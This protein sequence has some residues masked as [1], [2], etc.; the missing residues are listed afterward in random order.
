MIGRYAVRSKRYMEAIHWFFD[1]Y[2]YYKNSMHH[3]VLENA[4][5]QFQYLYK[6]QN[7]EVIQKTLELRGGFIENLIKFCNGEELKDDP[8]N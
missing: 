7:E 4:K 1:M 8:T 3:K 6:M 5:D 2:F